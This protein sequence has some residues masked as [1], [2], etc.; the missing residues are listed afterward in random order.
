MYSR[1]VVFRG[2]VIVSVIIRP[3]SV[4]CF[5]AEFSRWKLVMTVSK[6]LIFGRSFMY[7]IDVKINTACLSDR[8]SASGISSAI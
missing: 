7:D 3:A 5:I 8:M 1:Y 4:R 2:F 6:S